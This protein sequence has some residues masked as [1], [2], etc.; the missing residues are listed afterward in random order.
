MYITNQSQ[1]GSTYMGLDGAQNQRYND[2]LSGYTNQRNIYNNNTAQINRGYQDVL[3]QQQ[4]LGESQRIAL[5]RQ[6]AQ[7]SAQSQQSMISRG[8]GN[9]TVLDAGQRGINYDRANSQIA[10]QDSLT[11]E[12]TAIQQARL[13]YMANAQQGQSQIIGN[14]LGF[15]GQLGN[16]QTSQTQAFHP[17]ELAAAQNP[18]GIISGSSQSS[19]GGGYQPFTSFERAQSGGG[20]AGAAVNWLPQGGTTG[21][22]YVGGGGYGGSD[23]YGYGGE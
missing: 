1:G 2:I 5:D 7:Q 17:S 9:S 21:G 4:G 12:Q 22:Y 6:Y 14:R 23:N 10:L 19:S 11:R 8:M 13:G 16:Q 3:S 18:Y 20:T 15:M